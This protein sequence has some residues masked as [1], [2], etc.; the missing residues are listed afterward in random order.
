MSEAPDRESKTEEATPRKLEQAREKGDGVKT[1]DLG[2]FA[3]LAS[4]AAVVV[5]AGGWLSRNLAAEL[6][7]FLSRPDQMILTGRGGVDIL[8]YAALAG[9]PA[10]LIVM[11][12]SGASGAAASL[13]QTGLRFTPDKLK[14]EFSKISPRK[15]F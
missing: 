2:S 3:T 7:P 8:R 14:P 1:M 10:L 12:A 13:L 4:S 9:A 5:L 6:T 11:L 15:G